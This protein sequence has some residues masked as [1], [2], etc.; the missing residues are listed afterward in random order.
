[1][2]HLKFESIE[3][4]RKIKRITGSSD[5][6][7]SIALEYIDW[8]DSSD[9]ISTVYA[10]FTCTV[11]GNRAIYVFD[12]KIKYSMKTHCRKKDW[13]K[14]IEEVRADVKDNA[15]TVLSNKAFKSFCSEIAQKISLADRA[16]S[17]ISNID[18]EE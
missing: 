2:K 10:I 5:G 8:D 11:I 16:I 15:Q 3:S 4:I 12:T 1:M 14:I 6:M 18:E 13:A 7:N 9:I 17:I